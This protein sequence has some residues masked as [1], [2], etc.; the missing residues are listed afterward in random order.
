M[1]YCSGRRISFRSCRV[2]EFQSVI[3][4]MTQKYCVPFLKHLGAYIY[5]I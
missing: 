4:E 1:F 3:N 5:A 2:V